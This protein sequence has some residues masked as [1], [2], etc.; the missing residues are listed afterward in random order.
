MIK[1]MTFRA[2]LMLAFCVVSTFLI[3]VG[4]LNFW[5]LQ[6]VTQKFEHVTD[7]NLGNEVTL[8]G[9]RTA[10]L[11]A[12]VASCQ[13][14][15]PNNAQEVTTAAYA[16]FDAALAAY[17]KSDEIYRSIPFVAGEQQLYDRLDTA[18]KQISIP[19]KQIIQDS[20]AGTVSP[21]GITERLTQLGAVGTGAPFFGALNELIEFQTQQAK[22]W[23]QDAKATGS[24]ANYLGLIVIV[25]G[26]ACAAI[27][28]WFLSSGLSRG[29]T[30]IIADLDSSSDQ[31]RSASG[32]VAGS[33]QALAQ[34]ASEQAASVEETSATLEQIAS[35]TRENA[36]NASKVESL[37]QQAQD[38]TKKGS[39]AMVRMEG[40]IQ[41]IKEGSD[42]T[43][44]IV[45]TIDEI[46]FQTNLLALNAAVEAAR[47]GDAGRGFAVVAEEVRNLASRS[48]VAAKDTSALIEDSQ[49]RAAQGVAVAAEVGKLLTE[50]ADTASQMNALVGQVTNAS[51]EQ[52]KGVQQI[53]AAMAQMDQVTQGNA[54]SAEETAAA[55][56]EL[57]AQAENLAA[58]V[59]R[60][61]ALIHGARRAESSVVLPQ[62]RQGNGLPIP[63]RS[64][65]LTDGRAGL[66]AQL[67]QDRTMRSANA[68][69]VASE[70][71][72]SASATGQ[73]FRDMT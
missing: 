2:K 53:T 12:N 35:M 25:I 21:I 4:G 31:T 70:Q 24:R 67:E 59:R 43:A 47:A 33:S 56:E 30:A 8:S 16:R 61:K 32:Q 36:D 64:T 6:R 11:T 48:A 57:S 45:K 51:K 68:S 17:E 39:D 65:A 27:L 9:M 52:N 26:L 62:G 40:A 20:K 7:I 3:V 44:R 73:K 15:R 58:T 28:G 42:K 60:M 34:G 29:V 72:Q 10:A 66:R 1:N 69:N 13:L 46:A 71:S 55:A 37:A 50:I 38:S 54:A 49:Q 14:Q 41:S 19:L 63:V 5:A 23:S 18:W 22:V